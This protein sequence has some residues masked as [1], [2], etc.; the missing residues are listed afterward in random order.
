MEK[1]LRLMRGCKKNAHLRKIWMTMKLTIFL[2]FLAISQMMAVET[3]SQSTLL[4]LNFKSIAVK[5]VLDEIER[6]SEFV[7]LYNSK[8]VDADRTVSME[9]QDQKISEVLDKLF[10]STEVVY[11]VVDRQIVLTNKA[12]QSSFLEISGMQQ[13]KSI[14]GKITDS[15]GASLPGVSVVIKGTTSG[16]ITD[17]NGN[18]SITKVPENATLQFSFVGMKIQEIAV[19]NQTTINVTLL[20]ETL[21][22]DEVVVVGYG[23][24]K[25]GSVTAAISEIKSDELIKS[26][27]PDITN[28]LAGRVSGIISIQRSGE[29]GNDAAEIFIRGKATINDN[30]PLTMVDGI[31]RSINDLDPNEIASVSVL[32]DASATAIYGTRGANGVILITTKKGQSGKPTFSYNGYSGF[33]NII[34]SPNYLNSYDYARLHNRAVL[35]DDPETP[36]S[37]LYSAEDLQK[38]KDHSD[39]YGHPDVDWWK[40]VVKPN[41][42]QHKHSLSMSGGS[43]DLKYFISFGYLNQDG[44][45]RS[46]NLKRYNSRIN[47]DANLTKTTTV[48]IGVSGD[49]EEN[50]KP[51]TLDANED[52]GVFSLLSFLPPNAFPVKNEDG[53]WASVDGQNPVADV[54]PESGSRLNNPLNLQTSITVNQVLDFITNG[55]ALKVVGSK[56]L[57][58]STYKDWFTP[59]LAYNKK[60]GET[61]NEG[62]LPK[63]YEGANKYNNQTFE[64]HLNYMRSVGKHDLSSLLLYTQSAYYSSQISA[65]RENFVSADLPQLFAGPRDGIDNSGSG[66]EGG[67]E[68]LLGRFSYAYDKKYFVEASFGYNGSENFPSGKRFGFFPS[69]ALGWNLKG[70]NFLQQVDFIDN[71]KLRGSYGEVGNDRV[72]YRRFMYLSPVNYGGEYVFGGLSPIAVPSL[73]FGVL[74]NINVSW[75][76][77]K[78]TNFGVDAD[79]MNYKFGVKLDVFFEKRNNILAQRS[80]SVPL[81]FGAELPVENIGKVSNHGVEVELRYK[82]KLGAFSYY[83]NANYTFARNEVKFIDEP[84]NIP[85]YQRREG[86]PIGQFYGFEVEGY[87]QTQ[88]QID[89]LPKIYDPEEETVVEPKLGQFIY[90]DQNGDKVINSD[91]QTA[92]GK[93][94]TPESIYGLT[95][96][97]NFKGFDISM[98]WQGASGYN[99]MRNE[100]A[101]FEFAFGGKAFSYILDNWTPDNPNASYPRLSLQ[102]NSYKRE[103]SSFWLHNAGYIRLKNL[104]L[105]Y[106]IPSYLFG[107]QSTKI[108]IY[109]SG[110]N[111]LTFSKEKDFDPESPSGQPLFYPITRLTSIGVN[112]TF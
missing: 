7:F 12:D 25:K 4:S 87:Y 81:F 16:T 49:M 61:L 56:D 72:G 80:E 95:L 97:G 86:H 33:Q 8:L 37:D 27:A 110:T 39:P 42:I 60:T 63:L 103:L 68:G 50:L 47:I 2:F 85:S 35:N 101:F 99:V 53:T 3:Y 109:L 21:G 71:L 96:G 77:A 5:D 28:S 69:M 54:S 34:N 79:F 30:A 46:Q 20:E 91:D 14:T 108:R 43:D 15:S 88:Q 111:L 51:G 29:P 9:F 83:V 92:I 40:E 67:R 1:M 18:Y 41:A 10:Q 70:E 102:D 48:T 64:L 100:E 26:Q 73:Q 32:K 36:T 93:S 38:Y 75:E 84:E 106:T 112:V 45:Y 24:Q 65:S 22:I 44:I 19:E 90:K 105:G 6:K 55:L 82:N 57:G 13:Q 66:S 98:L 59:Y 89:D 58:N 94:D 78:K 74:P 104:E 62:S 107:K 11:T 52:K 31:Q 23:T 76:R 17:A